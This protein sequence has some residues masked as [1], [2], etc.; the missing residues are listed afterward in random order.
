MWDTPA[1]ARPRHLEGELTQDATSAIEQRSA[2]GGW[3][4]GTEFQEH[5]HRLGA[6]AQLARF[7]CERNEPDLLVERHGFRFGVDHDAE[8]ADVSR[9][10]PRESERGTQQQAPDTPS[11][12]PLV[13]RQPGNAQDGQGY[14]GSPFRFEAGNADVA[15]AEAVSVANP[16]ITP[17]SPTAT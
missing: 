3:W 9:H 7:G 4:D 10:L 12:D 16:A 17:S 5:R 6:V 8:A 13:D 11:G 2:G 15:S 1:N 14:C